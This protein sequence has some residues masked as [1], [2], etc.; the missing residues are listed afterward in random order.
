M[1]EKIKE[2]AEYLRNNVKG[3]MPRIAII[4]GS[5]LGGLIDAL[6]NPLKINYADIPDFPK[7]TVAGHKGCFY[8]GNSSRLLL[9][10][11]LQI[12]FC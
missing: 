8:L 10:S 12:F 11:Q 9:F 6:E 7:T 4:L 5:G 3:E 2:T 1:L